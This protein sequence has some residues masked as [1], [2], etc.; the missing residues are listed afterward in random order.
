MTLASPQSNMLSRST[1]FLAGYGRH[2]ALA[3][4]ACFFILVAYWLRNNVNYLDVLE[5]LRQIPPRAVFVAMAMN[6]AVLTLYG[7]RLAAILQT[8]PLPCFL[9]ANVGFT[10]NSLIPFR[11]GEAV[12]I[13]V[14]GKYFG[15]P[16]GG[17]GAA[18]VMEKLYDL[19]AVGALA[20]V[21]ASTHSPIFDVPL[22]APLALAL[23]LLAS[24]LLLA[25]FRSKGGAPRPS[26]W[27]IMKTVRLDAFVRQAE[28]LIAY[29]NVS[30]A[31][32]CTA[33]IWTT[34]V[35][36]VLV[37]FRT[38][39]PEIDFGLLAAMTLLAI[40]ALAIAVPASPAGLGVFEAGIVAYLATAHGVPTEKAI[41][42]ALAYHFSITA[43]HTAIAVIFLGAG[44]LR[45]FEKSARQR[46]GTQQ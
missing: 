21:V 28:T 30:R 25:R 19:S 17:L 2:M 37:L 22:S 34:N 26:E 9:I 24:V 27:K 45:L 7:L 10:F 23:I 42:A 41:S 12:K 1:R 18:I 8:K 38:I 43:P 14:G 39:F 6:A 20:L 32:L 44:F 4:N 29:Q 40:G 33:L 15:F 36:L 11:I 16:L 31:A 35:C 3:L 46:C 13:Y 5:Q